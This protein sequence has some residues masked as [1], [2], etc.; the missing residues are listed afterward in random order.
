MTPNQPAPQPTTS[1]RRG[2]PRSAAGK[3]ITSRN[4]LRHGFSATHYRPSLAPEQVERLA[5]A[6]SED[7]SDPMVVA[8]AFKI[9]ENELLLND[10]AFHKLWVVE[11]LR[12]PY[13]NPFSSKDN[14][15]DLARARTMQS[16]LMKREIDARLPALLQKYKFRL[17]VETISTRY[18]GLRDTL[19]ADESLRLAFPDE[20][21]RAAFI[22]KQLHSMCVDENARLKAR[23]WAI[24]VEGHVPNRL[25]ALLDDPEE[26]D[27][28]S[29]NQARRH[30]QGNALASADHDAD[31]RRD[32]YE[33]FEAAVRDL[34][35][36]ERYQQRAWSRQRR[37][38]LELANIRLERRM[39]RDTGAP[40]S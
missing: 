13:A 11:R 30:A 10:I 33:A 3:A 35:R 15:L 27:D 34:V 38:V 25:M 7:D 31:E 14:S 29:E 39:R 36:M 21:D 18:V 19:E 9:A 12:E 1:K 37:A 24:N 5:Q 40:F 32:E 16:W 23:D 26:S 17:F 22:H 28:F 2:G 8:A 4:A 20:S 6:I